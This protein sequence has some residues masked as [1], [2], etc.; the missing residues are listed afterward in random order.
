SA[1]VALHPEVD[2]VVEIHLGRRA[3]DRPVAAIA[4]LA[5]DATSPACD[6]T[7]SLQGTRRERTG[8]D[9]NEVPAAGDRRRSVSGGRVARAKLAVR[10]VSPA[11]RLTRSTD[12]ADVPSTSGDLDDALVVAEAVVTLDPVRASPCAAAARERVVLRAGLAAVS[13]LAVA[14]GPAELAV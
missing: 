9:R 3:Q 13:Q 14:V 6:S 10:I 11:Q 12:R 7:R 4:E 5:I 8:G 1:R 2:H